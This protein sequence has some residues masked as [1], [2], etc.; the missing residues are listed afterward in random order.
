MLR[1]KK[2][3]TILFLLSFSA[4]IVVSCGKAGN[5]EAAT[6]E[7]HPEGEHPAAADSTDHPEGEHPEGEHPSDSTS[8]Q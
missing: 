2:F 6:E 5:T 3:I 8:V 4:A 1:L 7:E